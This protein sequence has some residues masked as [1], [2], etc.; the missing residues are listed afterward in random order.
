[1]TRKISYPLKVSGK[2]LRHYRSKV[3][4]LRQE[5][6]ASALK[7][8]R[9]AYVAWEKK[10]WASVKESQA[11]ALEKLLHV[12]ISVLT[13]DPGEEGGKPDILD[14]PVIRSLVA[15]SEYIMERVRVLEEENKRLREL[16]GA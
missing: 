9:E 13:E 14:H 5:D 12:N 2:A 8:S 7:I 4:G 15:Q 16:R 6:V 11:L 3:P 1:M 10:D